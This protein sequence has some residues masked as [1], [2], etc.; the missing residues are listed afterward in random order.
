MAWAGFACRC[1]TE[2]CSGLPLLLSWCL[3]RQI[4]TKQAMLQAMFK[5]ARRR[6]QAEALFNS[7]SRRSSC[8]LVT[9]F[10]A[11][12][13]KWTANW[14]RVRSLL[15]DKLHLDAA[16]LPPVSLAEL[17]EPMEGT[18]SSAPTLL[19]TQPRPPAMAGIAADMRRSTASS[20][21]GHSRDSATTERP[22]IPAD[23]SEPITAHVAARQASGSDAAHG[24]ERAVAAQSPDTGSHEDEEGSDV[25][26]GHAIRAGANAPGVHIDMR[27][28]R[29]VVANAAGIQAHEPATHSD[30]AAS[31]PAPC[32]SKGSSPDGSRSQSGAGHSLLQAWDG[33]YAE[34]GN[35]RRV[36]RMHSAPAS[37]SAAPTERDA[38][39]GH[40]CASGM[41][42]S[43]HDYSGSQRHEGEQ[44]THRRTV[45]FGNAGVRP[46]AGAADYSSADTLRPKL[47]SV[48]KHSTPPSVSMRSSPSQSGMDTPHL[49]RNTSALLARLSTVASEAAEPGLPRAPASATGLFRSPDVKQTARDVPLTSPHLKTLAR[50][51]TFNEELHEALLTI[52]SAYVGACAS[53]SCA[54]YRPCEVLCAEDSVAVP[55]NA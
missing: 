4:S 17:A 39:L 37:N 25:V 31:V 35:N 53:Y 9:T 10:Q 30:G 15:I 12:V 8:Q 28:Q 49:P 26:A 41:S 16:L 11:N 23:D 21:N 38:A 36:S 19:M 33:P 27:S 13:M 43:S 50:Q 3:L 51:D 32:N 34:A 46:T 44:Y 20:S 40:A 48:L 55:H 18:D 6:Q 22:A 29:A 42:V 5:D 7:R 14:P 45:A 1:C 47:K 2:K 54:C 52:F 24:P